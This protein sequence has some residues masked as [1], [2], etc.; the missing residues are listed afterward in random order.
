MKELNKFVQYLES[1][2][3]YRQSR[4]K[5]WQLRD[6][7]FEEND[8]EHMLY[9]SQIIVVLNHIFNIPADIALKALSYGCC[10]DYVE[11]TEE[12]LGDVNYM[13][14]EKNP[15]L[16]TIVKK[17]EKLAMQTVPAFFE[18]MELCE[19]DQTAKLIVS[20]ADSIEALLYVHREIK[21]NVVKDEWIQVKDELMV[22]ITDYWSKL[23]EIFDKEGDLGDK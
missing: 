23:N 17:Q 12:S 16:K 21:F 4:V 8:A 13:V 20:L 5:R 1:L 7:V 10:H 14:K 9:V 19:A 6:F 22:R 3:L 18:T 11:S 2:K 15:E